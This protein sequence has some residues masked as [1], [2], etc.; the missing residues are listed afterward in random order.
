MANMVLGLFRSKKEKKKKAIDVAQ[1]PDGMRVYA[2]GDIHGRLDLMKEL[3][4]QIEVDD[5]KRDQASTHIIFLGD[6]VDRGPDSAGVVEM[7]MKLKKKGGHNV[8]FLMGNHEEVFLKACRDDDKKSTRFFVRIGGEETILS[9]PISKKEYRKLDMKELTERLPKIVPEQ[10]LA[11]IES[12]EDQIIFG[13]YL[14]V[15]A[16]IRPDVP[17]PQQKTSDLRW[18]R[19][20]F[21]QH[22]DE[23]E[24][25]VIYGHTISKD[26]IEKRSRIGVDTGAYESGRL[27]AIGLQGGERWYLQTGAK[28]K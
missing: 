2:I 7:A 14:F 25:V 20:D 10:H 6:L 23:F 12:F 17:L 27:T 28:Y 26:V 19:D 15:H 24:K 18:I 22:K 5:G 11:F 21:L 9:Y 4:E 16:G 8:R 3:L 1:L 13:D